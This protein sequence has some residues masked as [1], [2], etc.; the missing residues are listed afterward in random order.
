MGQTNPFLNPIPS[1]GKFVAPPPRVLQPVK[2]VSNQGISSSV[3]LASVPPPAPLTQIGEGVQSAQQQQVFQKYMD[4]MQRIQLATTARM[5]PSQQLAILR[6]VYLDLGSTLNALS[7]SNERSA[8]SPV[9]GKAMNPLK[10]LMKSLLRIFKM[11][12]GGDISDEEIE[13]MIERG[14]LKVDPTKGMSGEGTAGEGASKGQQFQDQGNR[15]ASDS[16]NQQREPNQQQSSKEQASK[17]QEKKTLEPP[18]LAEI[19]PFTEETPATA[20]EKTDEKPSSEEKEGPGLG[21]FF[22]IPEELPSEKA[23]VTQQP[24]GPANEETLTKDLAA[25]MQMTQSVMGKANALEKGDPN[26]QKIIQTMSQ[27]MQDF[28]G[29][30]G[31][32]SS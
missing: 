32:L 12:L 10:S 31:L 28:S 30:L 11:L 3:G 1:T 4:A 24:A 13:A 20:S 5:E 21:L 25:L 27:S 23:A 8:T 14:P 17:E 19:I 2:A 6:G 7:S 22:Q 9:S 29:L 16:Q 15:Q 26:R 18:P